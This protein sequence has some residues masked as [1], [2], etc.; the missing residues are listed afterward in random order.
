MTENDNG[1]KKLQVA[2]I[3]NSPF[4]ADGISKFV[5]NNHNYFK[6]K[7]IQYHLLYSS[8][9][10]SADIVT[11]YVH[12]FIKNGDKAKLIAKP[13]RLFLYIKEM[14]EYFRKENIDIIH[15]H[16]S[17]S[18]I[19][20]EM[21]VAKLA[22]VKKIISHSH[23]TRGNH[24]FI[25]K[26]L[27]P[28]VNWLSDEK[29]ACGD[30]AGQWMYGVHDN[31]TIIPNCIDTEKYRFEESVRIDVRKKLNINE[32]TL[33]L[34]HVGVF[35]RI[36]N[37]MFLIHLIESILQ[38]G[39][40]DIKLLLVGDGKFKEQIRN[41]IVKNNLSDYVLILG[42]RNDVNL[43]MMAMDIFCLPSL[44]EG[45]PIV[46]VEAQASGL[47]VLASIK[48]SPEVC[49]TDLVNLLSIDNGVYPWLNAVEN[50]SKYGRKRKDYNTQIK[51]A[52]YDI[53]KSATF[54]EDIYM[55]IS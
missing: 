17:S 41:Y 51:D 21:M 31:F 20:L 8:T 1:N 11:D 47:P 50:I 44:Y 19:L 23:N 35:S 53:Q 24:P 52:G 43:L 16:G 55:G 39:R 48:I 49:I 27:R 26:V 6:R 28:L 54:L 46:A 45:F 22:R 15:V 4:G 30:L 2:L 29:L 42:N 9:H 40:T 36:K 37:Q 13:N 25:H 5:L 38:K 7:N 33:L 3:C 34:G 32:G 10:S 12:D 14:Y 18:A